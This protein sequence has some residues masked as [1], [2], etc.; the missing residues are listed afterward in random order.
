LEH[1]SALAFDLGLLGVHVV[2]GVDCNRRRARLKLN[3]VVALPNWK[4][5]SGCT[6]QAT[7]VLEEF[8][9]HVRRR[10]GECWSRSRCHRS[11][12]KHV[13]TIA[14]ERQCATREVPQYRTQRLEPLDP[15]HH[16]E[17]A[18][19]QAIAADVELLTGDVNEHER[20]TAR[21]GDAIPIGHRY[22]QSGA[23]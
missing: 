21:M 18:E 10:H 9:H 4:E 2:V 3:A 8:L 22:P 1:V 11:G 19:C 14:D 6:E 23:A 15:Q 7:V 17:G 12:P 13:T 16:V 20:A 5:V